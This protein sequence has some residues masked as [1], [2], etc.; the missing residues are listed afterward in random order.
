MLDTAIRQ[1]RHGWSVGT[2]RR[3][4]GADVLALVGDVRATTAE[5]GRLERQQ[6]LEALGA[7]VDPDFRRSLDER[8]WRAVVTKADQETVYYRDPLDRLGLRPR[9]L[10]LDR[11]GELPPTPKAHLRALPEVFI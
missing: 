5:F 6:M 9:D 11:I 7:A 2:G 1:L 4:R 8:R 10:T 3:I